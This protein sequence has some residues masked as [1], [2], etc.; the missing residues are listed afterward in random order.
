MF[1]KYSVATFAVVCTL[2][3]AVCVGAFVLGYDLGAKDL[4]AV[5]DFK[6][7]DLPKLA[8]SLNSVETDI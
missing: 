5:N 8:E 1:S 4:A 7:M 2:T 3:V 6:K